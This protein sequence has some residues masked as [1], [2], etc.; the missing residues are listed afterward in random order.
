MERI[1]CD[2]INDLLPSYL[3]EI[4][5]E[6]T[7]RLVEEHFGE[8][9]DCRNKAEQLKRTQIVAE[10]AEKTEIDG[11]KKVKQWVALR[12]MVS[13]WFFAV[14]ATVLIAAVKSEAGA[15]PEK[16][17]YVVLALFLLG[18]N[19]MLQ[20]YITGRSIDCNRIVLTV[21]SGILLG[22]QVILCCLL[23]RGW[24]EGNY[25]FGMEASQLGPF[26][27]KQLYAILLAQLLVFLAGMILGV[28]RAGL[29]IEAFI[30]PLTSIFY[31]LAVRSL[32]GSM[33]SSVAEFQRMMNR[34]TIT[35]LGEGISF[36]LLFAVM[37]RFGKRK[38]NV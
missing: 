35:I 17:Y 12:G 22:Y 19:R 33:S 14:A 15:V 7:C 9:A 23:L 13:F 24:I 1:S 21:L 37:N 30:L 29:R 11:M 32:L 34:I 20:E 36:F 31:S 6:D 3:E 10:R 18:S 16:V 2:V 8:C 5:S 26:V 27:V 4:C 38:K 28:K 25:P